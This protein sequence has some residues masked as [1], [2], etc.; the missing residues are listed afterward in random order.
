MRR[1][2]LIAAI[3]GAAA[4][5]V[6]AW[7]QP[8]NPIKRIAFIGG[9]GGVVEPIFRQELARLGWVEGRNVRIEGLFSVDSRVLRAA[10]PFVVSSTPDL[11]VV[12]STEAAQIFKEATD[13]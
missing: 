4:C 7:A 9:S 1:R 3:G 5:P 11:I 2:D 12:I 13:T 6:V 8:R 10:A